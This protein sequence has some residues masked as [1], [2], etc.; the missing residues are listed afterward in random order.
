MLS[1]GARA[2]EKARLAYLIEVLQLQRE[3]MKALL[4]FLRPVRSLKG[5]TSSHTNASPKQLE[6]S[7]SLEEV[8]GKKRMASAE[9]EPSELI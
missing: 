6:V 8:K 4:T 9:W 5:R 3:P 7:I 2:D 1:A